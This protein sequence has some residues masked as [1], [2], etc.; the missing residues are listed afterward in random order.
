MVSQTGVKFKT[1]PFL[2]V[3]G[4]QTCTTHL[5]GMLSSNLDPLHVHFTFVWDIMNTL[6]LL[7]SRLWGVENQ[8]DW[9]WQEQGASEPFLRRAYM[10]M[11][12]NRKIKWTVVLMKTLKSCC[13][14]AWVHVL[15]W[16]ILD[17]GLEALGL[18]D[19]SQPGDWFS[20]RSAKKENVKTCY[21]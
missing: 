13:V 1:F 18:S 15:V 17:D 11:L 7:Y 12:K 9:R 6:F 20:R 16:A 8:P 3:L 4:S 19:W 21:K 10:Q 2:P 5:A 14:H